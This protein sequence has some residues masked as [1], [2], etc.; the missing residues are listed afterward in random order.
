MANGKGLLRILIANPKGGCGKST[1]ST[2]LATHFAWQGARV[3][4]GDLD[5]QQSA[6]YWLSLRPA[7]LPRI[8]GWDI[9]PGEPAKAPAGT[10]VAIID[11][12]AGLHGK[13]LDYA[14]KKIDVVLV[15]VLPSSF[16]WWATAPFLNQLADLARDNPKLR[17]GVIAMRVQPR[18]KSVLGLQQ[19]LTRF[20]LPVLAAIRE[21]QRYVQTLPRGLSIFDLPRNLTVRDRAEWAP[22]LTWLDGK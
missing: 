19:F 7:N 9:T 4:L 20:D 17:V 11:S 3:M 10:T 15:P 12:P 18:T 8:Q 2:N 16:D 21:T 14:L 5:R 13:K 1:L 6:A 22:L